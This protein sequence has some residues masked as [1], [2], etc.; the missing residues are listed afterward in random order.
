MTQ[1][2]A[3]CHS[4]IQRNTPLYNTMQCNTPMLCNLINAAAPC[5]AVKPCLH[6][7]KIFK[8]STNSQSLIPT[9]CHDI[10][11]DYFEHNLTPGIEKNGD[12]DDV[13]EVECSGGLDS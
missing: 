2:N 12:D 4:T 8:P 6:K 13:G 1:C 10:T 3:I 11:A 7:E 9:R 5:Y